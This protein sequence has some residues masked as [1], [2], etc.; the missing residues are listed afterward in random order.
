M[1]N[2]I[3][4]NMHAYLD[5][6]TA[7]ILLTGPWIF[8]F[9]DAYIP[10]IVSIGCGALVLLLSICTRYEG[11][12]ILLIP[13]RVHLIMDVLL[14]VFLALS[15]WLLGFQSQ[16]FLFHLAVGIFS[17]CAGLFSKAKPPAEFLALKENV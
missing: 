17:V 8:Y 16:T 9:D 10:K 5:Y 6:G 4:T 15:P 3:P 7:L 13:M 2:T 11:G 12:Y 1:K 14:G